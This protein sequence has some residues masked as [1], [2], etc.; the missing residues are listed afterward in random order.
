MKRALVFLVLLFATAA[1]VPQDASQDPQFATK[2]E[3]AAN[4]GKMFSVTN[5]SQVPITVI[6]YS[7]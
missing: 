3:T 6:I 7:C 1:V 4:G 5:H 2:I